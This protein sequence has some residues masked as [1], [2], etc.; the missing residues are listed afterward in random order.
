MKP[1]GAIIKG[2]FDFMELPKSPVYR[3]YGGNLYGS[4]KRK[5][6]FPNE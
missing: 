3:I 2:F 4:K 6:Q 5:R 1:L